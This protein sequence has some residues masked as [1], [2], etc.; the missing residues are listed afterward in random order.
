MNLSLEFEISSVSWLKNDILNIF[1]FQV[2]G[3]DVEESDCPFAAHPWASP[4]KIKE[5]W[6]KSYEGKTLC[7]NHTRRYIGE[8]SFLNVLNN[9]SKSDLDTY[10]KANRTVTPKKCPEVN[11]GLGSDFLTSSDMDRI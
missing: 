11:P 1:Y 3:E 2:I 4:E 5:A 7:V 6:G 8:M 10:T 9:W